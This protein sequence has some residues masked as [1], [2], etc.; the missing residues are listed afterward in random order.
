[1]KFYAVKKGRKIGIFRTWDECKEQV[2]GFS[3][4]EYK[5]F[6]NI[7]EA[8]QYLDLSEDQK[9]AIMKPSEDNLTAAVEKIKAQSKVMAE[10][11]TSMKKQTTASKSDYSQYEV[12]VFTDG[13]CRNHG[14]VKGGHVQEDDKAAWAYLIEHE[15]NRISKAGGEFGATNNKME[16]TGLIEAMK[17]ILALKLN[18]KKTIFVLDSRYVLRPITEKWIWSW[19]NNGWKRSKGELKNKELWQELSRLLPQFKN[20]E[21]EWTHGHEDN[22]GNNFVDKALNIYM[23]KM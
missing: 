17:R 9:R 8:S 3:G 7:L 2:N 18:N 14:N 22:Y 5:S 1:M 11:K 21:F 23:D 15:G 20:A 10:K 12:V 19:R 16:L 4:A 6:S 13:G